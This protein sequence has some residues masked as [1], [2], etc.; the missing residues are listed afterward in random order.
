MNATAL[1]VPAKPETAKPENQ[2]SADSVSQVQALSPPW[3]QRKV[4]IGLAATTVA[5]LIAAGLF[6]GLRATRKTQPPPKQQGQRTGIQNEEPPETQAGPPRTDPQV[7]AK[8]PA[9]QPGA[10]ENPLPGRRVSGEIPGMVYLPEGAFLFGADKA[11][12]QLHAFYIDETEVTNADFAE[13]CRATG[14]TGGR[15]VATLPVVDVTM[16]QARAFAEWKGKRL[17]TDREWERAARGVAG[18]SYPWGDAEDPLR[19]NV[20]DNSSLSRHELLP[21]R[22]IPAAQGAYQMVGNAWEMVDAPVTPSESAVNNLSA[23]L[24][25]PPT[26]REKWIQIRGGSFSTAVADAAVYKWSQIPERFA[27]RNIGFRCAK[28]P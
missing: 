18:A 5:L 9:Q 19:A 21:V 28:S 4:A 6:L 11:P 15:G 16:M 14:C 27:G 25:P 2:T 24:N 3:F 8:Q 13:F 1:G 7:P 23:L 20:S 26:A 22:S 10:K 12:V 17:P